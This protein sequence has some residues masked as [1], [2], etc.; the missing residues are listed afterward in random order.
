MSG[1]QRSHF[2]QA[3][4]WFDHWFTFSIRDRCDPCSHL[5]RP[6]QRIRTKRRIAL[7]G[8]PLQNNLLE[9]W[10]MANVVREGQLGTRKHFNERFAEPIRDG[11]YGDAT[12]QQRRLMRQKSKTLFKLLTTKYDMM[13]RC[14]YAVLKR[15]LKPKLEFVLVVKLSKLQRRLYRSFLEYQQHSLSGKAGSCVLSAHA[16]LMLIWN[17]P[18]TLYRAAT[19]RREKLLSEEIKN[20]SDADSESD[21]AGS[22]GSAHDEATSPAKSDTPDA[23]TAEDEEDWF[24]SLLSAASVLHD[25]QGPTTAE[26][27]E[28][29]ASL[30]GKVVILLQILKLAA[31]RGEKV[32]VFSQSLPTLDVLETILRFDRAQT[33]VKGQDYWRID[34]SVDGESRQSSIDCFQDERQ[35]RLRLFLISIRAGSLGINLTA[36]NRVIIFDASWNP[37]FDLQAMFRVYRYGQT[38]PCFVYRLLGCGTME[39]QI[40]NRQVTKQA[41]SLRVID[42]RNTHQHFTKVE[43]E[44]LLTTSGIDAYADADEVPAASKQPETA[45][46]DAKATEDPELPVEQ[47]G[48]GQLKTYLRSSHLITETQIGACVEKSELLALAVRVRDH[49]HQQKADS[50]DENV[51]YARSRQG[52]ELFDPSGFFDGVQVKDDV[53]EEILLNEGISP[54]I[55]YCHK[56]D[57]LLVHHE[58]VEQD[59]E[60]VRQE[61]ADYE[62]SL[63]AEARLVHGTG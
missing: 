29:V 43:I 26:E 55:K 58:D 2:R 9:Y 40:Y 59:D 30:S 36:A 49:Y 27:F 4:H 8:S 10:T 5:W 57:S 42:E 31:E 32:L 34:G 45:P 51:R 3:D 41:L 54:W 37:T 63:V 50:D 25:E 1:R 62:A 44:Q 24:R 12:R 33:W 21:S 15:D 20:V 17:H 11:Q 28:R 61:V 38:K 19:I 7:S 39:E 47:M 35:T 16:N 53:L 6:L 23:S 22:S 56:H 48:A 52:P 46:P 18:M 13:H 14:D 60:W